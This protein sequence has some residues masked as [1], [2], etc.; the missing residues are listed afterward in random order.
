MR[1]TSPEEFKE[2]EGT[3]ANEAHAHKSEKAKG[4]GRECCKDWE[5]RER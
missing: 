1:C 2:L 5:D 3:R 4:K